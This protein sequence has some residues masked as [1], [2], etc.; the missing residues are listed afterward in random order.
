[1][2]WHVGTKNDAACFR[3]LRTKPASA[4]PGVAVALVLVVVMV[5]LRLRIKMDW[6]WECGR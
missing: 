3:G 6:G 1:M 4:T 5:V 2:T